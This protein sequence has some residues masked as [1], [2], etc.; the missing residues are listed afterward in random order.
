MII[1]AI[2]TA[3][4]IFG[5]LIF[6]H[7]LGHFLAAKKAGV[8]VEEFGFGFPPRIFG[9]KKGETIYS[10]NL[11]PLGGFVKMAG[12]DDFDVSA[13]CSAKKNRRNFNCQPVYRRFFIL[14]SGVVM[15][16]V[17]AL[18]LIIIGFNVGMPVLPDG[19]DRFRGAEIKTSILVMEVAKNS[20]AAKNGLQ[21][22]DDIKK[23][24]NQEVNS[25]KFLQDYIN[26]HKGR[27]VVLEVSRRGERHLLE[28]VP[29]KN[30]PQNEGPL[31]L[32]IEESKIVRYSF[33]PAI[34]MGIKEMF[35]LIWLV[36]KA[37]VVFFK[38]IF[39]SLHV[40]EQAAG[41]VG[42]ARLSGQIAQLGFIYLLQF[43]ALLTINLGLVNLLPFPG[44]DGGRLL[45]L[46]IEKIRNKPISPRVEN[47]I[48]L[49]G[50]GLLILLIIFITYR[51]I[52]KF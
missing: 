30:P 49:V 5:L 4:V 47:I 12:Q 24:N 18:V 11:I 37:L 22:G 9:I 23:I 41:P 1:V 20:P 31:G 39:I 51:D 13:S 46:G 35:L 33:F 50:F 29:R 15:N 40:S 6:A 17:L 42:I 2:I 52:V 27:K 10:I 32:G 28:M 3:V 43:T 14:I 34:W 21:I 16:L 38:D 36:A 7:E 25:K 44:L 48:H 45:F 19:I 26:T 8:K